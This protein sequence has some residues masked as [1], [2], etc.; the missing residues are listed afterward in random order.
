VI[1]PEKRFVYIIRSVNQSERKYIGITSDVVARL[2][3]HDAGQNRS[4]VR[5]KPWRC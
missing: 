1:Y 2:Q 5:W 4:T 3:M